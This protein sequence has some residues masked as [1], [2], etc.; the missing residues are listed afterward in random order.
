L[1]RGARAWAFLQPA[2]S[3]RAR[4][5]ITRRIR[6]DA[7]IPDHLKT[8][9]K[10]IFA[11][12][13]FERLHH[14]IWREGRPSLEEIATEQPRMSA[15]KKS[16]KQTAVPSAEHDPDSH[17]EASR[18]KGHSARDGHAADFQTRA[19]KVTSPSYTI[20]ME[21]Q[22]TRS[23]MTTPACILGFRADKSNGSFL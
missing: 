19:R 12:Q 6:E 2:S 8:S 20:K 14:A 3:E 7:S 11:L 23:P 16:H 9:A 22:K 10:S 5:E 21:R 13:H 17:V 1:I 18:S 15:S 4:R